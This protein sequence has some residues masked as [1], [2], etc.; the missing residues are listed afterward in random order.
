MKKLSCN[1]INNRSSDDILIDDVNLL[2]DAIYLVI[3]RINRLYR[4]IGALTKNLTFV[5]KSLDSKFLNEYIDIFTKEIKQINYSIR[6]DLYSVIMKFINSNISIPDDR[7]TNTTEYN[8]YVIGFLLECDPRG[9]FRKMLS[10]TKLKRQVINRAEELKLDGDDISMRFYGLVMNLRDL[11]LYLISLLK[12]IEAL[13]DKGEP[14]NE[15][16]RIN[17]FV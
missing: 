13:I 8:Y 9:A 15:N 10:I 6:K 7:D 4:D 12:Q 14:K 11:E 17:Q 16:R 5:S 2:S 1:I 3:S